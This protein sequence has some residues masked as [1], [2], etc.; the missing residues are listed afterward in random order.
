MV[1]FTHSIVGGGMDMST[2]L[3]YHTHV[4]HPYRSYIDIKSST[5]A[6]GSRK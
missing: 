3:S 1:Y 4:P 5:Q 6:A 2:S